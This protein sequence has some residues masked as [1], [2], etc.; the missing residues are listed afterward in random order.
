MTGEGE[1]AGDRIAV[2][3]VPRR[4]DGDRPRR[5]RRDELHLDAHGASPPSRRRTPRPRM[6]SASAFAVPGGR[7]PE[8]D[9]A[10]RCHLS[11]RDPVDAHGRAARSS[12]AISMGGLRFTGAARSAAFVA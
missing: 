6:I 9:E 7:H 12:S 3:T 11:L 10:R 2:R 8:V 5:V 1:E 4:R